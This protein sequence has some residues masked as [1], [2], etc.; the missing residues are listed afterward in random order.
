MTG[1]GWTT[2]DGWIIDPA[3]RHTLLRG[4]NLGG[5]TK[6]PFAPDGATH[7]GAATEGWRD[8]SFVGR[9]APLDE[10]DAHLDRIAHWGFN[11]LRLLTTWEAI[12]HAGPGRHDE[13]YLD[14]VAEV[15]RR[16]GR[17]GLLV[18]VDPHHDVW[19][20]WTGGDGAPFWAFEL[21]GLLPERFVA[22]GAVEL[23]SFDW[24]YN[25]QRVPV[26]TMW[27][28]FWAGD[29][30]C[31]ELAGVQGELQERYGA[32]LGALAER[33]ADLD[34]VLGYDTLNEPS[35][36][37]LGR[38]EDL[39]AGSRFFQQPG[40][41]PFSPLEHLAAADGVAIHRDDGEVLNP[42]GL[43][44]WRD[45]CPW[46]RAGVWELDGDGRPRLADPEHFRWFEGRR[47]S[48]WSDVLVPFARRLRDRLRAIHPGC[49]LFLEGSPFDLDTP[50]D[51]PDPLVVNARHWYDLT[52]LVTRRFDP[53]AHQTFGLFAGE[54]RT[55]SGVAAIAEQFAA[56]LGALRRISE[57][58]MGNRPTL[59]GEFGI[60]YEMNGA[61]A[62]RTGDYAAQEVLLDAVY[63]AVDAT[64]VSATQ[65]NYT[66]DNTHE[67]GDQW[68]HEDLSV[69]SRS[70]VRGDGSPDDGGRAVRGFSRPYV[71]RA[72]GRP[73]RMS[74]DPGTATFELEL[75]VD[76]GVETPTEVYVP[77]IHYPAGARASA[78]DGRVDLDPEAQLLTWRVEESSGPATL[79]L[80]PS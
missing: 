46:R 25:Y 37:Y 10:L 71:R 54:P 39:L 72:Q 29:A 61:E 11:A 41:P 75:E 62:Y 48:P 35:Y 50:W 49:M 40:P 23:H 55:L 73:V 18:F 16:A 12:E 15:V 69:F 78:S 20:R 43:S 19:S 22:A 27:T 64:L 33:L 38:G 3:G 51:D 2:R 1:H 5:S 76:V 74:F 14:Y 26:A 67:H 44:I 13:V 77:R 24:G 53:A 58:R 31:P 60:P 45:G 30:Y 28:L 80:R 6:V 21:A 66:A 7:L 79:V 59:L 34:N 65:W 47:V 4:V 8:V 57:E 70:D 42:E 32:A 17:H 56:E 9:P 52:S 63:R 36:G 68:N